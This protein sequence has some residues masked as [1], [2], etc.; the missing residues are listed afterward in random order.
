[1]QRGNSSPF[2]RS[3]IKKWCCDECC[4]DHLEKHTN[5]TNG[6]L[7]DL[8]FFPS[9]LPPPPTHKY[10]TVVCT[11]H[12]AVLM[13]EETHMKKNKRKEQMLW[14]SVRAGIH[15]VLPSTP[16]WPLQNPQPHDAADGND[17]DVCRGGAGDG[18][19]MLLKEIAFVCWYVLSNQ[20]IV[21][22]TALLVSL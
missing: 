21:A 6:Q 9:P 20:S 18:L 2:E 12:I 22:T 10:N 3:K 5:T 11:T 1:M 16:T 13:G 8:V 19:I 7:F 17:A 15:S 4:L 14:V